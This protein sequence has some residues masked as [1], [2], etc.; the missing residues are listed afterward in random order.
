MSGPEHYREAEK[1]IG[2]PASQ[3]LRLP[4]DPSKDMD[5]MKAVWQRLGAPSDAKEYDF[6]I[7]LLDMY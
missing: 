2:A 1:L 6:P 3:L 4:A 7:C 5:G